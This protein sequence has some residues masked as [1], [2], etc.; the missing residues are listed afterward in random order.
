MPEF[1]HPFILLLLPLAP[2]AAWSCLRRRR[3]TLRWPDLRNF[4]NLHSGRA[5]RAR[6][7]GAVLYGV[8]V[9]ALVLALAGPRWRDH[10]SRI[11][12]EGIAIA[13][14]LDVSGSM[15]ESDFD[16]NGAPVSRLAA[17]QNAI[18]RFLL[19]DSEVPGR[20]NDQIGLVAFAAHPE[21]T[22]PLTL[23]HTVLAQL[24]DAEEPRS[25]PDTGTN[26]GDAIAWALRTLAP[27]D[28]RR[29]VVVLVSDGEHNTPAPALTPRQAAQ[30]AASQSVPIYSIQAGPAARPDDES[31][32]AT[33]RRAA[34][35]TLSAVAR[36]TGGRSFA[37]HDAD[38]MRQALAEIDRLER[39]TVESFQYRRYFEAF[40]A[41]SAFAFA[42]LALVLAL[43]TTLW[44]RTP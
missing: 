25:P 16:W 21:D 37:A 20:A 44:R 8:A 13:I 32:D 42:C 19:G 24:L 5:A 34:Q 7:G 27:A 3:P 22:C 12:A 23:S 6:W 33:A 31:Q 28:N 39:S 11:P 43:E 10:G 1:A 30:L 17:A 36:M 38:S 18:R 41:M 40:P 4:E 29:R 15:A 26:I 9:A 14:A 2:W 35:E